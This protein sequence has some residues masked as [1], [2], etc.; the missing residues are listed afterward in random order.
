MTAATASHKNQKEGKNIEVPDFLIYEMD[1][2]KPIYYRGY[3]DV[4]NETKTVEQIIGSSAIHSLLIMLISDYIGK[5]LGENYLRLTGELG[6]QWAPKTWRNIDIAVYD[7]TKF[8]DKKAFLSNKHIDIAP[9]IVIEIDTKADLSSED[10]PDSY[11]HN[12]TDQLLDN[13]VEKVIWLFTNT[14]KFLVAEKGKN[15][16]LNSWSENFEIKNSIEI[17]IEKLLED[18]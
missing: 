5:H 17:N 6:Y 7:K 8:K 18:F 16:I 9:E 11:F 1:N 3:Q 15:W 12:K 10:Y 14:R 4:L 2:G 13:G